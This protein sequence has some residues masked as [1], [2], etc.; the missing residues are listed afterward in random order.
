MGSNRGQND[1]SYALY[2]ELEGRLRVDPYAEPPYIYKRIDHDKKPIEDRIWQ[3]RVPIPKSKGIRKSLKTSDKELALERA[4]E[5]ILEVKVTMKQGGSALPFPVEKLVR[6]FLE[7][8]SGKVRGS[9]E[10]KVDAGKKSI[11]Q[12]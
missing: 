4:E 6:L 12:E 10:G 1:N 8:N 2:E 9:W 5:L 11:T 7:N 3:I